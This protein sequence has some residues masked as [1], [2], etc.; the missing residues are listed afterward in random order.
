MDEFD[1]VVYMSNVARMLRG[2][3]SCTGSDCAHAAA[4]K[5]GACAVEVS[6]RQ[7]ACATG[8]GIGV[9]AAGNAVLRRGG[10]ARSWRSRRR[11]SAGWS[12]SSRIKTI[13][14]TLKTP[15]TSALLMFGQLRDLHLL[16]ALYSE[17][18]GKGGR[19]SK[20]QQ[21]LEGRLLRILGPNV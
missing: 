10:S 19:V 12:S 2:D 13:C 7:R 15:Q 20:F 5:G 16:V 11:T 1:F 9:R 21:V 8:P 4:Q 14:D 17:R 18:V 6:L 3:Y